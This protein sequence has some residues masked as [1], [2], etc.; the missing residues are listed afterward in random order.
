MDIDEEPVPE[1]GQM[2]ICPTSTS[3]Y[4]L[5]ASLDEQTFRR[6]VEVMVDG[7]AEPGI[8]EQQPIVPGT[9]A[10]L[11]GPWQR[12]GGPPGGLGYDIRMRPDNPEIM[13]VTD[14]NAGIHKSVDGGMSWIPINQ[15]IT[16]FSAQLYPVFC[17]TID[18]HN[19]DR[20]WI[21]TQFTG[22]IYLSLDGGETWQERDAGISY[23][24]YSVRGITVDPHNPDIVYAG[25]EVASATWNKEQLVKRFDLTKG[26]VYKSTNGGASWQRIWVGD[27]LARYIWVDPRNANRLYV[28]TGIFDRDAANS[29]I[30]NGVW[31]GVGI[32]RS[33]DAGASWTV[34]DEKNGLGGLYIPS[35]FMHPE[36]PDML[37]AA[38][39]NSSNAPGAYLTRNGGDTWELILPMPAGF[40][41]EAVEISISNP[42]V[43]YV[44]AESQIW[45]SDDA[46]VT[47]QHYLMET[48]DR[49]AGLPI[50]LQVDPR[51]P[52]RIFVNNYGGGNFVSSN[53][54]ETWQEASQGYTG[55]GAFVI[56]VAP[57]NASLVIT[58]SFYSI[59]AGKT[60]QGKKTP[61]FSSLQFFTHP[62]NGQEYVIGGAGDMIWT[63]PS[64]EINWQSVRLAD[65]SAELQQ[66]NILSDRMVLRGLAVAP[67]DNR[68]MYAGFADGYCAARVWQSCFDPTPG[69]YRSEDAG[70]SWQAVDELRFKQTSIL[71]IAIH[72]TD[73]QQIFVA[74]GQGLFQSRDGGKRWQPLEA[75]DIVTQGI[76][77]LDVGLIPAMLPASMV[78][79]LRIDP[80]NA[81]VLYA[82][83]M[84]G[85]VFKSTDGGES[86]AQMAAG[87]DPNEP[88]TA[89]LPDAAHA[90][91]VYASSE[92]SGVFFSMDAGTHWQMLSDGL[93]MMRMTAITLS[94]DG[95]VLY[96]SSNGA[97][98]FRLGNPQ[99]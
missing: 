67:S 84:P 8:I 6:Q 41:A 83:S 5:T 36:N 85:G 91:V 19:Y 77:V 38:V 20:I 52:L 87:M 4:L 29:D 25:V 88:I 17:V 46:G 26:E 11:N 97:G 98:V 10:Y 1:H 58:K 24:G 75:L 94:A 44:A 86:W 56:G 73:S 45:R 59:D 23:E 21:G 50:D 27:N 74:T 30:P 66:G 54:G 28:S 47:W 40:G 78:F 51:D 43:W 76:P 61:V 71:A 96:G 62:V 99:P 48:A 31:G 65:I 64:R 33:D 69:L 49:Q 39:T 53:G 82:A 95:S 14:A 3:A 90:G 13:Y 79:D 7:G 55:S 9:P 68:I 72:P 22:Q 81:N 93:N 57:A 89:I 16:P 63:S 18:P 2:M 92:I 80:F 12:L 70:N 32:L 60:W 15:G 35:L 37:L 34:L 42:N